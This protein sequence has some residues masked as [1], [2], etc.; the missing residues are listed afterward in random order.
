MMVITY[1]RHWR[2]EF[3]GWHLIVSFEAKMMDGDLWQHWRRVW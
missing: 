2:I 1:P 3:A